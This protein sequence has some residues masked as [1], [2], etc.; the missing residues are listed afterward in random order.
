MHSNHMS[1]N[2]NHS[3]VACR[4]PEGCAACSNIL[5]EDPKF[6]R[7]V[8]LVGEWGL[9]M[10]SFD[11]V[12]VAVIPNNYAELTR[13]YCHQNFGCGL[14]ISLWDTSELPDMA[15]LECIPT[16]QEPIARCL[17]YCVRH[18]FH[19]VPKYY[20]AQMHYLHV[21]CS[22][23]VHEGLACYNVNLYLIDVLAHFFLK[24]V[25]I[26]GVNGNRLQNRELQIMRKIDHQN[27]VRLCYFFYSSGEKVS[28]SMSWH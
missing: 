6:S 18:V 16:I 8:C 25:I 15:F 28:K 20:L 12:T 14:V 21:G 22:A 10:A 4:M 19:L 9:M 7:R 1:C 26:V 17:P 11:R 13:R 2:I 3:A 24:I 23:Q 5:S 27:I